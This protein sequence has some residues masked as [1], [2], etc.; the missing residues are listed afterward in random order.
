V[1]STSFPF[2]GKV[3]GW[4]D[5]VVQLD[6]VLIFTGGEA[7]TFN[8]PDGSCVNSTVSGIPQP[9]MV[10]VF[11]DAGVYI[12]WGGNQLRI[13][14][15]VSLNPISLAWYNC[16]SFGNGVESDRIRDDF[17]QIKIDK[18]AKASSTI[19]EPYEE[20]HRRYGLIYSGI[21]NSNSG[22]NNLNQF[23]QAEK[24]TKDINPTYGS[25]QKLHARDTDLITLC[26]DKCLRILSSKD[27]LYNADGN[28]QLTATNNVLGQTIPFSGEYG[29]STNPESFASESFR[30]YFTDKIRGAVMRLSKDGLTPISEHGMRDWFRDNLKLSNKMIGSYDDRQDEYNITLNPTPTSYPI[31]IIGAG[32]YTGPAA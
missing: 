6:T 23:I 32:P 9:A 20:E 25:I 13:A 17:N 26:E 4:S 8:R 22:V 2:T 12:G 5:N 18:G 31:R 27:A 11:D 29:I 16:Y 21:Y 7:I 30:V 19:D 14:T 10:Q 28:P 15:D 24:I 1:T 3:I